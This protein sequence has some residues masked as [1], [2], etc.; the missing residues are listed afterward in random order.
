MFRI[1]WL[2]TLTLLST[3][4]L[5]AIPYATITYDELY[6]MQQKSV[7]AGKG[8]DNIDISLHVTSTLCG[9]T[10]AEI[11][12]QIRPV[13]KPPID[14]ALDKNGSFKLPMDP[15]LY[16]DNPT[17]IS[18]QPKHSLQTSAS[19]NFLPPAAGTS[20]YQ[21][22]MA[23]VG[24]IKNLIHR[25]AGMLSWFAPK[26]NGLIFLFE[27]KAAAL[28]IHTPKGDTVIHAEASPYQFI[29]KDNSIIQVKYDKDL[30]TSNPTVDLNIAPTGVMP[31][32]DPDVMK[33]M[34]AA[35]DKNKCKPDTGQKSSSPTTHSNPS[36]AETGSAGH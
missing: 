35:P 2:L 29:P 10:A 36:H 27:D 1:P 14:L 23:D 32:M 13:G 21:M 7:D 28:T 22:H 16:K 24:Q 6:D 34:S 8:L 20:D 11:H 12:L 18:N 4:A 30:Y 25:E 3:V 9:V 26:V 5:S 19:I 31:L 33:K 15:V 17:I